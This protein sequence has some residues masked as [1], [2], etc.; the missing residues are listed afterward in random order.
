MTFQSQ[1]L[2]QKNRT[3]LPTEELANHC[4]TIPAYLQN[5]LHGKGPEPFT[6]TQDFVLKKLEELPS[7]EPK[8]TRIER[9]KLTLAFQKK[10][11]LPRAAACRQMLDLNPHWD[12][13]KSSS[14]EN[15]VRKF[16]KT[17][18]LAKA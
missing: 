8:E 4:D 11:K 9:A 13:P 1:L 10:H 7:T 6:T 15:D 17:Q 5:W 16:I 12:I 18:Q 14:L 2:A 3:G